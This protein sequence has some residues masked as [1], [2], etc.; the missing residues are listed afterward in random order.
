MNSATFI[1]ALLTELPLNLP[2]RIFRSPMPYNS[3]DPQGIL[4]EQY[5]REKISVI[6]ML[7]N[8]EECIRETGRDLR[9]LYQT[10][11]FEISYF[12]I[13]DFGVPPRDE[14]CRVLDHTMDQALSGKNIVVH[15]NGGLGRTGMFIACLAKR[16]LNISG[17]QAVSWVRERIPGA[18]ETDAQY[19]MVLGC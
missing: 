3:S 4:F 7:V 6:V 19:K 10:N 13:P 15:C 2:G 11:G 14:L 1:P 16:V 8:V 18:I 9:A 5:Q 17:E 12:P